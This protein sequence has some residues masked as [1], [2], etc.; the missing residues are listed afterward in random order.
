MNAREITKV[1]GGDW[2]G[3]YG[4]VPVPGHSP[5]DSIAEAVAAASLMVIRE[6]FKTFC[7]ADAETIYDAALGLDVVD[8]SK[9]PGKDESAFLVTL[10]TAVCRPSLYLAP[11]ALIN[12]AS[13]SGA[14]TGKGL[15]AR[16]I[17][18]IAFGRAPHAVTGGANS[19]ELEKRIASELIEGSPVLFLDNL[20]N[21]VLKSNLLASAIT[22]R[23]AR[24]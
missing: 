3:T 21:T 15:L 12:A 19:E 1:R 17:C 14:G 16:C 11:G 22:E 2:C 8:T 24:G 10:L 20:N 23:P 13:M 18:M 6:T 5:K 9:P 4:M 7:F